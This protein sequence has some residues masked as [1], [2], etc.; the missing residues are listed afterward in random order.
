MFSYASFPSE[1]LLWWGICSDFLPLCSSFIKWNFRKKKTTLCKQMN[2]NYSCNKKYLLYK[3]LTIVQRSV[4]KY[5]KY[6]LIYANLKCI[7]CTK[8]NVINFDRMIRKHVISQKVCLLI[9]FDIWYTNI[10]LHLIFT[11]KTT[12][13]DCPVLVWVSPFRETWR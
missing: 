2:K 11:K 6:C 7:S 13:T 8:Q 9:L 12:L 10:T 4:L 1:Y 3:K 5:S